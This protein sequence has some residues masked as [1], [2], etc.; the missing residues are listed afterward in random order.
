M[1]TIKQNEEL[2]TLLLGRH[3]VKEDAV[4]SADDDL[5][6]VYGL[7]RINMMY[8]EVTGVSDGGAGTIALN[9]KTDSIA[10]AAATDIQADAVGTLYLVSGQP[11]CIL[12]GAIAPTIKIAGLSAE[13]DDTVDRT[14]ALSPMIWNGG[15]A[16]I[17]I[18]CTETGDDATLVIDWHIWYT[19]LEN[20]S[21]IE[22]AA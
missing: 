13:N 14:P 17:T 19:P 2:G 15:S 22:A 16:G 5:F 6:T 4:C 8:G 10:I 1:S 18:E 20:D 11:N 7:V 21:Y 3:I 12:N 9:E